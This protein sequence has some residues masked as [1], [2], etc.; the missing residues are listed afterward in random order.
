M[1][2]VYLRILFTMPEKTNAQ[3]CVMHL[4]IGISE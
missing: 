2:I 3:I 1:K 4:G